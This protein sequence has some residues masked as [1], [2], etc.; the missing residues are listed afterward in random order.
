M[1]RKLTI[2]TH[3]WRNREIIDIYFKIENSEKLLIQLQPDS[4]VLSTFERKLKELTKY[5]TPYWKHI[6]ITT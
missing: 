6:L 5:T 1:K 2:Q 4:I 3:Y